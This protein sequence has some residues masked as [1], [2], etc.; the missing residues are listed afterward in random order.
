MMKKWY[1][2]LEKTAHKKSLKHLFR[3]GKYRAYTMESG[4]NYG[5]WCEPGSFHRERKKQFQKAVSVCPPSA[6]WT[7]IRG[8][9]TGSSGRYPLYREKIEI[10]PT[11][12]GQLAHARAEYNSPKGKIISAWKWEGEKVAVSITIPCNAE[13][14]V[15]LPGRE[16]EKLAFC[17]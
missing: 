12:S 2:F 15:T 7:I 4:M 11:I 10:R 13:A 3:K 9:E 5:E 14:V 16:P 17:C 6:V 1:G 8:G